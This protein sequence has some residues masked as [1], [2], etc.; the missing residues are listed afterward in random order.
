MN[1][2]FE[3]GLVSYGF[4]RESKNLIAEIF[5]YM[6]NEH[7]GGLEFYQIICESPSRRLVGRDPSNGNKYSMRVFVREGLI[8]DAKDMRSLKDET[9]RVAQITDRVQ[10][11]GV[12]TG[13]EVVGWMGKGRDRSKSSVFDGPRSR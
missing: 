1:E 9:L 8:E 11:L 7:D 12:R 10:M 4:Q 6:E 2:K 3:D 5:V 13:V